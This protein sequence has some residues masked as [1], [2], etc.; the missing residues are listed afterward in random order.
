MVETAKTWGVAGVAALAAIVAA[1]SGGSTGTSGLSVSTRTSPTAGTHTPAG[2]T[3][4]NGISLTRIRMAVR[5]VSVEGGDACASIDPGPPGTTSSIGMMSDGGSGHSGGSGGGAGSD[6]G[7]G[8]DEGEECELEFGPFDVDLAGTALGSGISFAFEA[9]IPA[10]TYE[11]VAISVNTV[12]AERAGGNPVLLDLAAAH[13]S[14]LVDGFVDDTSTTSRPFTFSTPIEV[15]QKREG[16]IEIGPG[17]NLTL[18]FDP[19]HWFDAPGGG[20]LDPTVAA[21]QGAILANIRASIRL[22]KDDDHDGQDDDDHG[23]S[24]RR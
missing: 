13:A 15:K 10:G 9:P 6:D 21:N 23:M 11:E 20:R 2:L 24:G 3:L 12:P 18:D 19:S 22:L 1:C 16:A 5:K 4:A 14:I 17:S 7:M 8:G